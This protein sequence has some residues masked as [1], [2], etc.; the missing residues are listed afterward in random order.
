[1]FLVVALFGVLRQSMTI[2]LPNAISQMAETRISLH[3]LEAFLLSEEM[4]S[5]SRKSSVVWKE[6]NEGMPEEVHISLKDV[7]AKWAHS[8]SDNVLTDVSFEMGKSDMMAVIGMVGSGKSSLLNLLLK[9]LPI[10]S[11]KLDV[12]GVISYAAQ[13]PWLFVGSIKQNILF[14]QEY[15]HS[16]YNQVLTVCALKRDLSL[17]PYGDDTII[18]ERGV[19]LSGGQRARVNLA[20]AIYKEADI[21]LLDDPLSA[22]DTKVGNVIFDDCIMEFLQGK[23]VILATHQLQYLREVSMIMVLQLGRVSFLGDYDVMVENKPEL[24]SRLEDKVDTTGQERTKQQ[25][26]LDVAL[27]DWRTTTQVAKEAYGTGA[28]NRKI[29]RA[30]MQAGGSCI[31]LFILGVLFIFTQIL[32]SACDFYISFW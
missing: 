10:I 25:Y 17:L 5:P 30:Y 31:V 29:Y 21:Y 3:R 9:E 20:R 22:V 8:Q 14:G 19:S 16:R 13:E 6:S 11:G 27:P 15:N 32:A 7:S 24:V 26:D 28:V 23:C 1:M 12:V 18:G 2:A 4:W